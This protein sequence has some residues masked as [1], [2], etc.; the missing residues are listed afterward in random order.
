MRRVLRPWT[1]AAAAHVGLFTVAMLLDWTTALAIRYTAAR[2]PL[3]VA[4]AVLLTGLW[5]IT[6]RAAVRQPS[7][8]VVLLAAA[9]VGTWVGIQWL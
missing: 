2:D 7:Y 5:W 1:S 9:G 8:L 6:V 4:W 3:A